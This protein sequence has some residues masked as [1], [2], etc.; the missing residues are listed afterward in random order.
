MIFEST[1]A[2]TTIDKN[3]NDKVV[4]VMNLHENAVL[5]GQVESVLYEE[6]GDMTGFEVL[7]I[8]ISK[9]KEI[10]NKKESEEERAWIAEIQDTTINDE[11]EEVEKNYKIFFFAETFDKAHA[12]IR[13]YI[14]QGYQ[15]QLVGLKKSKIQGVI[16]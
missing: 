8:K 10:A 14:A 4:K 11:G 2:Y 1:I 5:F 6:Y 3:G 13:N 9:A 15:M 12:F 16:G 7:A